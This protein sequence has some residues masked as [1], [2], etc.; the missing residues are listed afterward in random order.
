MN[1]FN[2][3]KQQY[4]AEMDKITASAISCDHTLKV[5][6]NIGVVAEGQEGKFVKQYKNLYIF[7]NEVGQIVD[8][9]LTK[10][11]S[12]EKARDLVEGL[13]SRIENNSDKRLEMVCIDDCCKL[14]DKYQSVFDSVSVKLDLFHTVQRVAT[15]VHTADISMKR[16]FQKE[17]GQT[18]K[19]YAE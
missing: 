17:F 13:K 9:R 18:G 14:R 1:Y 7:L 6:K 12:F 11:T 4:I 8:W 15:T 3:N 2:S 19:G 10:T 16:K 5:S